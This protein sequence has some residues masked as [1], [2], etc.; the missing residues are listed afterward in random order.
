MAA[1][2]VA[3]IGNGIIG[4]GVAEVFSKAGWRVTLIGRSDASLQAALSEDRRQPRD[5][6]HPWARQ[7]K[8][9]GSR[10]SRGSRRRRGS[11]R[12]PAPIW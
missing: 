11:M 9:A 6:R 5:V 12:R 2:S 7:R 1:S 8:G 10:R 4:H 3:V